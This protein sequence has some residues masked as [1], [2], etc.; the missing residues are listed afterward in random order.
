MIVFFAILLHKAPSAFGL[1]T[2]LLGTGVYSRKT[3]RQQ[4]IAFS[5]AA[6]VTAMLTLILLSVQN[7]HDETRLLWTAILL[8]FSG[9]SFLYVAAVH[10]LPEV[11][12]SPDHGTRQSDFAGFQ[13]TLIT[14][15]YLNFIE[16]F[17]MMNS[18]GLAD[19]SRSYFRRS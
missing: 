2:F 7:F 19:T 3:V 5:A 16:N 11:L 1:S 15:T 4:I 17:L 14:G 6:P 12:S 18:T 8:L 9:G 13:I 10:V